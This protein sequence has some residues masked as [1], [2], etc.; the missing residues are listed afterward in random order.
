MLERGDIHVGNIHKLHCFD[1]VSVVVFSQCVPLK[2][3]AFSII[4]LPAVRSFIRL[5]ASPLELPSFTCA[6]VESPVNV[7]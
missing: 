5:P 7:I 4:G 2:V 1:T 6:Q 3:N